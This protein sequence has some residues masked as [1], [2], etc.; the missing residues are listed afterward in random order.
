MDALVLASSSPRRIALL[1]ACH[2]EFRVV[3]PRVSEEV[4]AET[5]RLGARAIVAELAERKAYEV[6]TRVGADDPAMWVLGA[7][8]LVEADGR[9]LG[10]PAGA[11]EARRML[12]MLQGRTHQVHT[13]LALLP[14][15]AE[16][17]GSETAVTEVRFR[18][19][20]PREIEW[21]IATGEWQGAA[22]AYRIQER[23]G[24][25]VQS[26]S[27]S[28]SNVV[29]LPLETFYGMLCARGFAF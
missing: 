27:G 7:D 3:E 19:L 17:S 14:P 26:I 16:S 5:A 15:A 21:Y 9:K 13:G 28:Y 4:D 25:L 12:G 10:K 18:A 29:G 11:S 22:G 1:E 2:M 8:T 6:R 20:S 24:M 23:G